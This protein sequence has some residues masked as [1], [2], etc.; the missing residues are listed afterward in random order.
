VG[1][2]LKSLTL[3][4]FK[5]FASA[6]TLEF[7]P[8]ITCVVGPNGSGKSN[9]VDAIAWVM[10][11][12][13]A[14]ALRGG[15]MDDVIFQGTD[16]RAPLGR[17]E[18][19]LT[20][21]NADGALPVEFSEVTIRRTLFRSGGSEYAI[22]GESCRLLDV[23]E[24]LSDSGIGREMHVIVGQGRLDS[25]LRATPEDRRGF[26]EEAAGVL[27]HRKRKEKALRKLDSMSANLTRLQD[28]THE[29][30]RQLKPLGRQAEVARRSQV[31][32][33]DVRDARLR[34][35]A[36]DLI[37]MSGEID[38]EEAD[39][40]VL[41]QRRAD[42]EEALGVAQARESQIEQASIADAAALA[43]ANE[44]HTR[45]TALRE[46]YRGL[47]DLAQDRASHLNE[48][49]DSSHGYDPDQLEAQ[50]QQALVTAEQIA[51]ELEQLL[52]TLAD[53]EAD[54][55]RVDD[56]YAAATEQE[57][58][59]EHAAAKFRE[60]QVRLD[61]ARNAA[62]S[63]V[64]AREAEI[65]RLA[66]QLA[67]GHERLTALA[68]ELAGLGEVA[69][70][71]ESPEHRELSERMAR[72]REQ[73]EQAKARRDEARERAAAASREA[74]G[75]DARIEALQLSAGGRGSDVFAT[76]Q[77]PTLGVVAESIRID[78]GFEPAI[79]AAL[80]WAADADAV[81]V[82]DVAA[83]V[84]ALA[85]LRDAELGRACVVIAGGTSTPAADGVALP[86]GARWA[87]DLVH[88]GNADVEHQISDAVRSLLRSTV[89][90]DSLEASQSLVSDHHELTLVSRQGDVLTSSVA[91]GGHGKGGR[92]EI[93]AAIEQAQSDQQLIRSR[94][95]ATASEFEQA[96]AAFAV[97]RTQAQ[98]ANDS[99]EAANRELAKQNSRVTLAVSRRDGAAAEV[100]RTETALCAA[101]DSLSADI[102][103]RDSAATALAAHLD[104]PHEQD[105]PQIAPVDLAVLREAVV[106][107]R[108][109]ET[110]ARLAVR[111]AE[112]RVNANK[113]R[114][115]D[116]QATA[117]SER[118]ARAAALAAATKRRNQAKVAVDVLRLA[119]IAMVELERTLNESYKQR[120][121][122][123][124]Q[125]STKASELGGLRASIR[126][127]TSSIQQLTTDVH[128]DE[129]ARAEQRMRVE[130]LQTRALEE[131]GVAPEELVAEY[132]PDVPVP[133][134]ATAP[135]DEVDPQAP[136]P[137]PYPYV[138]AEQEKRLRTAEKAMALLGR[139]NPL[140]LEEFQA[141]EERY[142]F[143]NTQLED[144]K[145]SR[146][147]LLEIVA[148][149]DERV[150]QVFAEA[151]ADVQ[152]E[153]SGVFGRLFP[154][155]EGRLVL[156]DPN[157]LLNTGIEVEA[158][159][160]GKRVKRLSLL[161]GGERSLTAVA[162]LVSLFKA[163]P[164]P[165]YLLDEVEAALDDV[166]L[167]RL[168]GL[169]EELRDSSQLLIITHQK[170]TMEIADALYGVTMRG[171]VTQVIS[172][173]LREL[174]PR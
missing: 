139:V 156:T 75:I 127:L 132:G 15:K 95:S 47:I 101:R 130:Q 123:T 87:G 166:N 134:S 152:R 83:A 89:I 66:S 36:D 138:R 167:G 41:R 136:A 149:V 124:D 58:R 74:A 63:K 153:F 107:A 90:V 122:L 76:S 37:G 144:L 78:A 54:C 1:V 173:R 19:V 50:A 12:Q 6:T 59:R 148:E 115:A 27:K 100:T 91:A 80:S 106:A 102:A 39:E 84:T 110:T 7:E 141:M 174:V 52:A 23:Q 159:P 137:E 160:A 34:I 98:Q 161:S 38:R 97:T 70:G 172:Q 93:L 62:Q 117:A 35:L 51:T 26:V 4:G 16:D 86:A 65:S 73:R 18:V 133:P 104:Q 109:N 30:R 103:K 125:A 88:A 29:L 142:T 11:E 45:L 79:E 68:A 69:S 31:I 25:I 8:G 72:A 24:L 5:S 53:R 146:R 158:R 33:T 163:R 120:S 111:T 169:M 10:G 135:G 99:F 22:N 155:G 147:D 92:L 170:R 43:R 44:L 140:A 48:T 116:L 94:V 150:Q 20:I 168:L 151:F 171:G 40:A 154:G 17:A 77:L 157:D 56:E 165:F 126:D 21:D 162:F 81:A 3:R 32:Q 46:R 9:V 57:K 60:T 113:S 82:A 71:E 118:T 42:L 108:R 64:D 13:G 61:G 114:A 85:H 164:S 14:K 2:H 96:E 105:Q 49:A 143:L 129:I 121:D 67:E 28:L 131:F 145:N 112:E 128:R 55:V 119:K